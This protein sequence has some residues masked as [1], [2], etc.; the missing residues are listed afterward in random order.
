MTR[1]HEQIGACETIYQA[2]RPFKALKLGPLGFP[3]SATDEPPSHSHG[4]HME[5][6]L[7]R[8]APAD[9]VSCGDRGAPT[10]QEELAPLDAR[11]MS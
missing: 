3:I 1:T 7:A 6:V 10:C 2:A 9:L 8:I 5:I 4:D 11:E